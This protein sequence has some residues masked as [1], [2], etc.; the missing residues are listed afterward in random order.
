MTMKVLYDKAVINAE[1]QDAIVQIE[2]SLLNRWNLK[3]NEQIVLIAGTNQVQLVVRPIPANEPT[4]VISRHTIHHLAL[5]ALQFPVQMAFDQEKNELRIAPFLSVLTDQPFDNET[6][7]F[8]KLEVFLQEMRSFCEEKGFPLYIHTFQTAKVEGYIQGFWYTGSR[9][10]FGS[11]PVPDVVY[12]RI[13]SR[14]KE[15]SIAFQNYLSTLTAQEIPIF[16][17]GFLSKQEVHEILV[18][19]EELLHFL[20]DT[21]PFD[22]EEEFTDFIEKHRVVY[23]KPSFGSQGRNI[24]KLTSTLEGWVLEHSLDIKDTYLFTTVEDL[25]RV[26]K[27]NIKHR[28]YIVQ[29]GISLL[30]FDHKKVD[31]RILLNKDQKKSWKITSLVARIGD[32]GHI[33]SN[34]SRGGE[35]QNGMEFLRSLFDEREA[36]RLY[37]EVG[38]LA[39][40]TAFC[41]SRKRTDLFG[42]LGIDIALDIEKHPWIIELNSKPSKAFQGSYEKFRPSVK[43]IVEYMDSLYRERMH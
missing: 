34:L 15:K 40:R 8:G 24:C 13:H 10:E 42:E 19:N 20:P 9:W 29:K 38:S 41:L 2:Q 21:I 11:L 17:G 30:E 26:L 43:S 3:K 1:G 27:I 31:F 4:L 5:P 6:G 7:T 25:F 35:M 12:N 22:I 32:A 14:A 39:L 36:R 23:V 37:K 28:S 33:V 18:E 16:N